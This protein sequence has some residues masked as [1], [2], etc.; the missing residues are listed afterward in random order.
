MNALTV[1]DAGQV[2]GQVAGQVAEQDAAKNADIATLLAFCS[3]P[4]T[5]AE[6]QAAIQISSREY[7]NTTYLKPLLETGKIV[8]T[9]PEKPT[10]SKQ[11]YVAV[12][13]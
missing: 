6:M 1:H 2:T 9:I 13:M 11:Q 8:M 10:S 4:K 12:S 3:Q 7:F 5:R